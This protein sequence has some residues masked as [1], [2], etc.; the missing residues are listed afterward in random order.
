MCYHQSACVAVPK[1]EGREVVWVC[2]TQV[3]TTIA[4][5]DELGAALKAAN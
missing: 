5:I 3:E 1:L 2:V 4:D